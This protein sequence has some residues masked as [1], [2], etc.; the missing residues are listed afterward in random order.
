MNVPVAPSYTAVVL[1]TGLQRYLQLELA[2]N[3]QANST[4]RFPRLQSEILGSRQS[5]SVLC[6]TMATAT[7]I[8]R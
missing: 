4:L 8:P 5:R 3:E 7:S 1:D 2:C 6:S